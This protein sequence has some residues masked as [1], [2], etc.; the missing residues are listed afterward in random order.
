MTAAQ[1]PPEA[2]TWATRV[3]PIPIAL[4]VLS[5]IG[6]VVGLIADGIADALGWACLTVPVVAALGSVTR[7]YRG[8]S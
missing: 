4:T 6:L 8:R 2:K 5:V 7:A 3:W 1:S